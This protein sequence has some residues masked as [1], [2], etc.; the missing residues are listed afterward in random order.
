MKSRSILLIVAA[1]AVFLFVVAGLIRMISGGEKTF[2]NVVTVLKTND[3]IIGRV[4]SPVIAVRKNSGPWRVSLTEDKRRR[5]FYSV[6]VEGPKGKESLKAFWRE[7]VDGSVEVYSIYKTKSPSQDE[8][9]W[10]VPGQS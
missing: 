8:L 4:G 3:F 2:L 6:T 7:L 1:F 5:G 9:V 10:G